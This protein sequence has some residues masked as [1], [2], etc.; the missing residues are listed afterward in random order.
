MKSPGDADERLLEAQANECQA[1]GA[2]PL[3]E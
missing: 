3:A 2:I 1:V